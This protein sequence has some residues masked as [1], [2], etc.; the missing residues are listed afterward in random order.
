MSNATT[1]VVNVTTIAGKYGLQGDDDGKGANAR[2]WNPTKM[3]YDNRNQYYA[4]QME[5]LS[6]VWMRRT[7]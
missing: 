2:F 1:Y 6:A 3:V 7:M 4:L 5:L